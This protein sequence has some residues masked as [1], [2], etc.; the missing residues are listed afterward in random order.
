M[1]TVIA[2]GLLGCLFLAGCGKKTETTGAPEAV[3]APKETT[4]VQAVAALGD[5]SV[6]G[7]VTFKGKPKARK[8]VSMGADPVCAS[9]HSEPAMSE[10]MIVGEERDGVYPLANVF[11]YVKSGLGQGAY[12]VP[13]EAIII[14]QRG[15][16]YAPHVVGV[17]VGQEVQFKNSDRTMHNVH[18][19]AKKTA[20]SFNRGMPAGSQNA[21]YTLKNPEVMAK[22]K[23]DA[24]PWMSCYIGAL[25][26]PFFAVT[27]E[28]G[29][30][31]L[32]GLPDG[33]YEVEAWHEL[34]LLKAASASV[35]VAGGAV[36]ANFEFSKTA[37]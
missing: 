7:L 6:T 35:T 21:V 13:D 20:S 26:H 33:E 37:N 17:Q 16:R 24:H 36:T 27:G 15:C 8:K 10:S 29:A 5:G 30:F 28:D 3:E 14:D 1:K 9:L 25:N 12:P 4:A 11:V 22:V 18:S 32:K 31:T 2:Y 34:S 23:C 19:L